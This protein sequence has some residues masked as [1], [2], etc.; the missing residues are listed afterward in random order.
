[1]EEDHVVDPAGAVGADV[2]DPQRATPAELA[3]EA[4]EGVLISTLGHPDQAPA[5]VIH[6]QGEVALA[7]AKLG[8][9]RNAVSPFGGRSFHPRP[10]NRTAAFQRIR[11][12]TRS[13]W[14]TYEFRDVPDERHVVM[15][16]EAEASPAGSTCSPLNG[17]PISAPRKRYRCTGV[18]GVSCTFR[19][20]V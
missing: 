1:V 18:F 13:R 6:D 19:G 4:V 14:K 3:K 7:F 17:V 15:S 20:S 11:L 10:P 12:S 16:G 5:V 9:G 2:G 8:R